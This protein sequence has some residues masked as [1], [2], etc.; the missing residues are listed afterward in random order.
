VNGNPI[1]VGVDGTPASNA[2]VRYGAAEAARVDADLLLVHV[3]SDTT[4]LLAM[5]PGLYRVPAADPKS[6]GRRVLLDA[7]KQVVDILPGKR[8]SGAIIAGSVA[9]G[10]LSVAEQARL[11]VLGDQHRPLV[12]RMF[13]GSV[14]VGVAA[15]A[16]RPVVAVPASWEAGHRRPIVAAV[17]DPDD[18]A[19]LVRRAHEIARARDARLV[20]LHA[21]Q[22]PVGYD[23]MIA[24]RVD[25]EQW[26]KE[27]TSSLQGL[28][29]AVH[30]QFADV[31]VELRVV[32]G[33]P[34]HVL[35]AASHDADLVLLCRRP[36]GVPWGHL[37]ATGRA[38]LRESSCPVE[39]LPPAGV[40]V[41]MG[42]LVL[43]E[44]G[45]LLKQT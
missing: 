16:R 7:A 22:L 44:N 5:L 35:C 30:D 41:D 9:D 27:V 37:G 6:F 19:G 45:S 11:L 32:H 29:D 23:D 36:H 38:V 34:A 4:S 43:E 24:L 8:I 25:E 42:G 28:V 1:V 15:R 18:S 31:E 21:W 40:P 33:Q 13:T 12:G 39:V 17:K 10:L 14:L 26:A 3:A 20:L 2:A